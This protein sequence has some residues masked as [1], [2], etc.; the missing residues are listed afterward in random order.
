[1]RIAR[2]MRCPLMYP[3]PLVL[4][5][6]ALLAACA[7]APDR[8]E[9]IRV[10]V[11]TKTDVITRYGQPDLIIAAPGGYTAV[12]RTTA[13]GRSAPPLKIPTAQAGPFGT[14]TTHM[15]QID[16]GSGANDLDRVRKER[17]LNE[18]RI[19]YNDRGIV[20]ELSYP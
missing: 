14:P 2:A 16:P 12:Y 1:M 17:L 4:A 15:Q 7:S 3:F 8:Q 5:L 20:Q 18:I 11:T 10:G 9:W 6:L 13:S 19:R